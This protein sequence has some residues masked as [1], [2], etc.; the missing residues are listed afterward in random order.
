MIVLCEITVFRDFPAQALTLK[1]LPLLK[2]RAVGQV[3]T[4]HKFSLIERQSFG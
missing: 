1:K 2:V 4:G 3:E